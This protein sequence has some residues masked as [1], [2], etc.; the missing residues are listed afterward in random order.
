M[1]DQ[2]MRF[3]ESSFLQPDS[4]WPTW[5]QFMSGSFFTF[6]LFYFGVARPASFEL[7]ALKK[8]LNAMERSV[9]LVAS[10]KGSLEETNHLLSVLSEQQTFTES[11][12][13]S[14]ADIQKLNSDLISESQRVQDAIAVIGQLASIKDLAIA[15][16]NHTAKATEALN[17]TEKLQ[18]RLI[19]ASEISVQASRASL[20]LLEIQNVLL[21][22]ADKTEL[23]KDSLNKLVEI[24]STLSDET[25]NIEMADAR[26][27]ELVSLKNSVLAGTSNIKESIETLELS[28]DLQDS[29]QEA[30][31]SFRE[32]RIW[33]MEMSAMQ[34]TFLKL[35]S[36]L[37]PLTNLANVER[38]QPEQLRD[39]AKAFMQQSK[40]RLASVPNSGLT[41][42]SEISSSKDQAAFTVE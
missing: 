28:R 21:L 7:A 40:T 27:T 12:R 17:A 37:E 18:Q 35:Q 4:K 16:S 41:I 9:A 19:E 11:A 31:L 5:L 1:I 24:R 38:M 29:F 36:A 15:N 26:L 22:D 34:P 33:M 39:F 13:K 8:Q 6:G 42:D 30:S 25:S 2:S 32:M 23:A 14:F 10:H 20:D 3:S